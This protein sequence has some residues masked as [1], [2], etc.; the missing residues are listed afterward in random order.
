M[1]GVRSFVQLQCLG[2]AKCLNCGY[3]MSF[4]NGIGMKLFAE[5]MTVGLIASSND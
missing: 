1:S 2:F 4:L 5:S 3:F